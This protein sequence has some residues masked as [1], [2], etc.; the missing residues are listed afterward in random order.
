VLCCA[1]VPLGFVLGY[2]A[3]CWEMFCLRAWLVAFLGFL[4]AGEAGGIAPGPA[5]LAMVIAVIGSCSNVGLSE[6]VRRY[7]RRHMVTAVMLTGILAGIATGA[8]WQ[9][10]A[11]CGLLAVAVYYATIM[12]DAGALI[13]GVIAATP[14]VMRGRMLGLNSMLGFAAG[15]VSPAAFGLALDL[16]GGAEEG[17]AWLAAFTVLVLPNLLGIF[18]LRRLAGPALPQPRG[19]L[20]PAG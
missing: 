7:G 1:T 2:A 4:L 12:A 14:P 15:L 20:Q 10:P 5:G 6:L 13:A 16:G 8:S 11:W 18:G 17:W 19:T 3:H 9:L